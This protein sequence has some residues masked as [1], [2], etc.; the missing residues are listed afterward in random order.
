MTKTAIALW[1]IVVLTGCSGPKTTGKVGGK[2]GCSPIVISDGAT[3]LEHHGA[4]DFHVVGTANGV[5]ATVTGAQ[6]FVNLWCK[7]GFSDCPSSP[8]IKLST[9]GWTLQTWDNTTGTNP[10]QVLTLT[11][12]DNVNVT[13]T[14]GSGLVVDV[15]PDNNPSSSDDA[16]GGTTLTQSAFT[17]NYAVF[18]NGS[19]A[20]V[21]YHCQAGAKCVMEITH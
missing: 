17:F 7:S 11:S 12:T 4:H 3:Y 13:S 8:K 10:V 6:T 15:D 5:Q 9:S 16:S 2:G 19:A 21:S 14:F 1:A 20:A 18:T